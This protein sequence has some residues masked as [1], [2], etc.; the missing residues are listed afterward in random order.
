MMIL[1]YQVGVMVLIWLVWYTLVLTE[2][3]YEHG[4]TGQPPLKPI[5][6]FIRDI[7]RMLNLETRP[8]DWSFG[9]SF[10]MLWVLLT[11]PFIAFCLPY[12]FNLK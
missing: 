5:V 7:R 11:A 3:A 6:W 1:F 2:C 9:Q 10:M 4:H 12:M 8:P